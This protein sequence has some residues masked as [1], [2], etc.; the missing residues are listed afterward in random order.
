MCVWGC[1]FVT[2][3]MFFCAP[4]KNGPS[5]SNPSRSIF[6]GKNDGQTGSAV[7]MSYRR[8]EGNSIIGDKWSN[9]WSMFQV[10]SVN[11]W[12]SCMVQC[13]S[14]ENCKQAVRLER[15]KRK[16]GRKE[17]QGLCWVS[18]MLP[19]EIPDLKLTR[20]KGIIKNNNI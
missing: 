14:V 18:S 2:G 12:L 19:G 16:E 9:D 5:L 10:L 1:T 3:L 20:M 4:K 8:Q 15:Q 7:L 6:P 17:M 11:Q 13:N